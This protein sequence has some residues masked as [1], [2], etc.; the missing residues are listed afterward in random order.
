MS[1]PGPAL[2][3][4][5]RPRRRWGRWL[6]LAAVTLPVAAAA[7][8]AVLV[9]SSSARITADPV[10][11]AD[12]HL[13]LGGGTI[14]RLAVLRQPDAREVAFRLSRGTL[15]PA[16][17]VRA[18]E[19]VTVYATIRRPGWI[20][21]LTGSLERVR[22]T[23]TTP[24]TTVTSQYVTVRSGEPV[25]IH[26]RE[27]V[28]VVETG[29]PGGRLHRQVY[30]TP[31]T[32]VTL[33]DSA[34]AGTVAVAGAPRTWERPRVTN[35]SWFPAGA[36]ATAVAT[37]APGTQIKPRTRITLTFSKPVAKVLGRAMPPV[38]PDT[39]GTWHPLNAHTITFV[40]EGY[41]YGLGAT[42]Q[43]GLPAG[44]HLI[45]GTV[46]GSDPNGTWTV[47]GGSTLRLQQLLAQL[48]YLPLDFASG[49]P[50][51]GTISAQENAAID[52]PK[53]SFSWRYQNTP[54]QLVG[55]WQPG[56]SGELTRGAVMAFEN[57]QGMTADGVAGPQVW[58][59]LFQAVVKNQQNTF[60]YTYV[61]VSEA[62]P[63]T[64]S[65]WHDGKVVVSGLANT[66]IPAAPTATGVFAV[67]EHLQST[68][69]SG[70]N[71]DGSYYSDPGVPWV[72]YFNGGD[73]LHGFIRPG[74]GYP[75]SLGCVEM[76]YS[77]AAQVWP[78]TPIGTIV[79]VHA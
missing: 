17:A 55:E 52:P 24:K 36:A 20:S 41:G 13:P 69:M 14:T 68:T 29:A 43:V 71:P 37:P 11:L 19:R 79:N 27:P 3:R 42:V 77:E 12:I 76:P 74:Y 64:V 18:G 72:S 45:G 67:F 70:H 26:F 49:T 5:D 15:E 22:L 25:R 63:E 4:A 2:G 9:S 44:V 10:A 78:Y 16:H 75:Q 56:A 28:R 47:P 65:V 7:I 73:A 40:P 66:G 53:G 58:K 23:I 59:A 60:G 51:A 61:N 31:V 50:V 34:T 62:S 32:E 48:G 21:W 39:P 1:Y 33:P 54:S 38:S 6:A 46:H 35:V 8:G 57:T 30:A